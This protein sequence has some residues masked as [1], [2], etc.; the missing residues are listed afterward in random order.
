[1][2]G[3][4]F[5]FSAG[6]NVAFS[7]PHICVQ[8]SISKKGK[9][10]GKQVRKLCAAFRACRLACWASVNMRIDHFNSVAMLSYYLMSVRSAL[11]VCKMKIR[12]CSDK[13][14]TLNALLQGFMI[15]QTRL[16]KF[17]FFFLTV[18]VFFR[19][20]WPLCCYRITFFFSNHKVLALKFYCTDTRNLPWVSA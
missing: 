1:M 16:Q 11:L 13:E 3:T 17:I 4:E 20:L 5:L 2:Q 8:R 6:C 19:P 7:M 18:L 10:K 12:S 9:G 14:K 15:S